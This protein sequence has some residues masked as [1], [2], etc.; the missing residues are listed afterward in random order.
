MRTVKVETPSGQTWGVR[1]VW[2]PRWSALVRR[3]G[4]WRRKR[5]GEKSSGV[6]DFSGCGDVGGCGGDDL[7]AIVLGIV[8]FIVGV[9]LFWFILLPLLLLVVDILV[10]VLLLLVAIPARVL[11]RRPWTVEAAY[12]D[13]QNEQIFSTDVVG[14]RRALATRDDIAAKL[15]QGYPVPVV[16]T[17]RTRLSGPPAES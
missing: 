13:G 8:L 2:Q 12:D 5:K 16:G 9:L 4:A 3:F 1:V 15:A 10:I 14:W 7:G 11:F 17:L 6:G